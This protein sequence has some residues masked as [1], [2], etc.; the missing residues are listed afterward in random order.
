MDAPPGYVAYGQAAAS[1][2]PPAAGARKAIGILMWVSVGA[3]GLFAFTAFA[4]RSVWD[5]FVESDRTFAD[6]DKVN[7]ADHLVAGAAGFVLVVTIVIAIL[8]AVWSSR[9]VGNARARGS[10]ASPGLAAGGWFIPFA[11]FVVPFVQ[12]RKAL[13]GRGERSLVSRWQGLWIAQSLLGNFLQRAFGNIDTANTTDEV[14]NRLRNQGIVITIST[15]ILVFTVI[16]ARKAM[17]HVDDVTS[18]QIAA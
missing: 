13:G 15:I 4:R 7:D 3:Y 1:A 12:L 9:A 14:S 8:L 18:G 10:D 2:R 17:Q 6:L 16:A 11:F 5:T